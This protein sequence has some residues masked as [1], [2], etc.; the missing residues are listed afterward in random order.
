M[1]WLRNI[2]KALISQL[3]RC[4]NCSASIALLR[5]NIAFIQEYWTNLW[6]MVSNSRAKLMNSAEWK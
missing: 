4:S 2:E 6:I 3:L 5:K 1:Y